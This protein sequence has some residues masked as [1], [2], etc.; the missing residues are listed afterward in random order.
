M[1]DDESMLLIGDVEGGYEAEYIMHIKTLS[2]F[3]GVSIKELEDML[4]NAP[5]PDIE[6]G[7]ARDEE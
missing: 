7:L 6:L 2:S 5:D 1:R 3:S 4:G